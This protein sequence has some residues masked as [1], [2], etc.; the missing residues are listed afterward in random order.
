[1]DTLP[2]ELVHNIIEY[3]FNQPRMLYDCIQVCKQW[4]MI[5][6]SM[7]YYKKMYKFKKIQD[8]F[9]QGSTRMMERFLS[10]KSTRLFE[11]LAQLCNNKAYKLNDILSSITGSTLNVKVHFYSNS[12]WYNLKINLRYGVALLYTYDDRIGHIYLDYKPLT[13]NSDIGNTYDKQA[14][15]AALL[16]A[17]YIYMNEN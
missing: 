11:E 8:E 9:D 2:C 7:R 12:E 5:V 13:F 6:V 15:D 16:F 10:K 17:E 1:M 14:I 3:T 4:H